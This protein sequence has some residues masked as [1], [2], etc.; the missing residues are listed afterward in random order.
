M[1]FEKKSEKRVTNFIFLFFIHSHQ[2]NSKNIGFIRSITC[3]FIVISRVGQMTLL[4]EKIRKMI[5]LII[6]ANHHRAFM[7]CY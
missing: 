2:Y 1:R 3:P 4:I 7:I 5:S 6:S